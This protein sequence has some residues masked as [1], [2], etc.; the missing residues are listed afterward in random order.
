MRFFVLSKVFLCN[1]AWIRIKTSRCDDMHQF[2]VLVLAG[3]APGIDIKLKLIERC[4]VIS[5]EQ[6]I[7]MKGRSSNNINQ[8]TLIHVDS[9]RV[10]LCNNGLISNEEIHA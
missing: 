1:S 7:N 4:K 10:S 9:S 2:M 6:V 5:Y 8:K 3:A